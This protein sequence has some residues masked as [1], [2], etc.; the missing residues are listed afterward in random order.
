M[1]SIV[2]ICVLAERSWRGDAGGDKIMTVSLEIKEGGAS[3][4]GGGGRSVSRPLPFLAVYLRPLPFFNHPSASVNLIPRSYFGPSSI[5]ID[6]AL[7]VPL[8][9]SGIRQLRVSLLSAPAMCV[10]LCGEC[11]CVAV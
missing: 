4:I 6:E 1:V 9:V 3:E 5:S 8:M 11:V 2:F 10:S 7:T